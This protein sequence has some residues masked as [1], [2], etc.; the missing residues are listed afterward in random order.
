MV[1]TEQAESD[2]RERVAQVA[3]GTGLRDHQYAVVRLPEG[4]M[5]FVTNL[6][7][8]G[9]REHVRLVRQELTGDQDCGCE[10]IGELCRPANCR[11]LAQVE[12][13]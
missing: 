2:L 6:N 13:A 9:L 1:Q 12:A 3:R 7:P 8:A 11:R 10:T 4:Q 5:T